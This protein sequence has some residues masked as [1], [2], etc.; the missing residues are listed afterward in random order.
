MR[1]WGAVVL[2][3]AGV[4]LV[5]IGLVMGYAVG[6]IAD[7]PLAE[8]GVPRSQVVLLTAC[9]TGVVVLG[10]GVALVGLLGFFDRRASRALDHGVNP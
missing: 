2:M 10:G 9:A 1:R 5:V 8:D 7:D 6:V 3:G 4:L